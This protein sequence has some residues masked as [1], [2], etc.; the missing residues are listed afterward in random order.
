MLPN[1]GELEAHAGAIEAT[2]QFYSGLRKPGTSRKTKES[3][4]VAPVFHEFGLEQV[5]EYVTLDACRPT[6]TYRLSLGHVAHENKAQ[7]VKGVW[8]IAIT[9]GLFPEA[10]GRPTAGSRGQTVNLNI[11][12]LS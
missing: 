6:W 1:C 8:V 9:H 10:T 2:P 5:M 12:L 7:W 3:N 4:M 11:T